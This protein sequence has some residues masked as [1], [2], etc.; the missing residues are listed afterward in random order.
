MFIEDILNGNGVFARLGEDWFDEYWMNYGMTTMKKGG[1]AV[2]IKRIEDF[3]EFKGNRKFKTS[4]VPMVTKK[5][6]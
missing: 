3:I 2:T 1:K 4:I 6:S 5:K